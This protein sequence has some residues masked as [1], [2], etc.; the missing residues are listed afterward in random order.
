[1]T[2]VTLAD[3]GL[4]ALFGT[5]D[6][7]LKQIER[8]F[9][10]ELSAR[11][12]EVRIDGDP[13]GVE[14]VER[15]IAGLSELAERGY[16]LRASEVRTAIRVVSE[17]PDVSLVEFFQPEGMVG[18]VRRLIAPRTYK[19]MLYLRA[20]VDHDLVISIG[21]AGTGKTYLAVAV[22]AA[23]LMEKKVRRIV[24]ARPAVEA[25]EK[26]GFLPGDL[27]EKVNPY[28]R[29][30]YDALY[31]IIGYEKVGRMIER[32]IIEVAPIAFMRGRTL[33]DSFIILDEAQ[34]TTTEQMKMFLTRIGFNS[35]A[36][37]NG[38]ITQVDLPQ[39]R[40]SGLKEAQ[41]VLAGIAGIEFFYFDQRD[42]VRHPLV[43]KI[44][45]AYDRF[46]RAQEERQ[47]AAAP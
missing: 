12:S 44:V 10:V 18:S 28:L 47:T 30:L 32:G 24:L 45:S 26:L 2:Q 6:E 7:N 13:A 39:G 3:Q 14:A 31:D 40:M 5:H 33:N 1:M 15:L 27:V 46:D 20:M 17:A 34:N 11:G 4:E 22:A 35:K 36:V 19:Q 37:I 38:D 25:G 21:P 42:V 41:Q 9:G 23:C 43:Q 16:R 29:P 8:T